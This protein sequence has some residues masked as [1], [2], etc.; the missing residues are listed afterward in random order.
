MEQKRLISKSLSEKSVNLGIFVKKK[1]QLQKERIV[2]NVAKGVFREN[3][4]EI[5]KI[6]S[7]QKLTF[8]RSGEFKFFC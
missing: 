8:L 4:R 6:G 1:R 2:R 5:K 7:C 3:N